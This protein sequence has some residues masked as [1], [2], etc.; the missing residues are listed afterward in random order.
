[1][2][3]GQSDYPP[4]DGGQGDGDRSHLGEHDSLGGRP[5]C[6]RGL[7]PRRPLGRHAPERRVG[8]GGADLAVEPGRRDQHH[9]GSGPVGGWGVLRDDEL[10][11]QLWERQWAHVGPDRCRHQGIGRYER[12]SNGYRL[13]D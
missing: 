2:V 4:R 10:D 1:M 13:T 11:V 9:S 6:S 12:I 3:R 7:D 8:H 5:E